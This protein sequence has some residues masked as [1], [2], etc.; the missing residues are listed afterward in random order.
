M[1][2]WDLRPQ[3]TRPNLGAMNLFMNPAEE[4]ISKALKMAADSYSAAGRTE[5]SRHVAEAAERFG[6]NAEMADRLVESFNIAAVRSHLKTAED[7]TSATPIAD[8]GVVAAA[9]FGARELPASK[10]ASAGEERKAPQAPEWSRSSGSAG[11]RKAA[12]AAA[13]A[14][15]SRTAAEAIPRRL[16]GAADSLRRTR[17]EA[18]LRKAA[19]VQESV[20]A[21]LRLARKYASSMHRHGFAAF[22]SE[23]LSKFGDA[24]MPVLESVRKAAC[25]PERHCLKDPESHSGKVWASFDSGEDLDDMGRILDAVRKHAEAE[26]MDAGAAGDQEGILSGL[27]RISESS[28]KSAAPG[29]PGKPGRPGP[30]LYGSLG[31]AFSSEHNSEGFGGVANELM[32]A[33]GMVKSPSIRTLEW[34]RLKGLEGDYVD[35]AIESH[36]DER[37]GGDYPGADSNEAR[38]MVESSVL[39]DLIANDEIISQADPKEVAEAFSAISR[40]SPEAASNKQIARSVLRSALAG[41]GALDPFAALQLSGLQESVM[42]SRGQLR[43]QASQGSSKK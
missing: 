11:T 4:K 8:K 22:Q 13:P 24:A 38:A 36:R 5:P 21:G 20:E 9:L 16:T 18:R 28:R 34:S 6:L 10:T 23:A 19:A 43:P 12:E 37:G 7:R 31:R 40:L 15:I 27:R 33:T 32:A 35:A 1:T 29:R 39:S 25:V 2:D 42:K 30:D 14:G 26:E 17:D 41:D 3:D